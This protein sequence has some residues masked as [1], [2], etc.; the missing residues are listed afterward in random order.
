MGTPT[1]LDAVVLAPAAILGLL[2]L[3]LG[4]GRSLVAWPMR[5][6]IPLFGGCVA[7]LPATLYL[8]WHGTTAELLSL[9]ATVA[10]GAI[11]F[12][13]TIVLLAMFMG[14]FRE[15]MTVWTRGRR[16]RLTERVIGAFFGIAC[17]L[18]LVGV[19][20]LPMPRA[21]GGEPAW[22]RGSLLLPYFRS[23]AEAVESALL[24]Y[25]PKL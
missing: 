13:V 22:A 2:G 5:W 11:S 14:N 18:L 15:R 9:S 19:A 4:L 3:W 10:L 23:A 20:Y 16:I 8:A 21:P 12:V 6:L 17:G 1:L 24:R 7:A 25:L